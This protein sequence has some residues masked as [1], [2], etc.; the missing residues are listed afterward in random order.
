MHY[1]LN[2]TMPG[3][4]RSLQERSGNAVSD[5]LTAVQALRNTAFMAGIYEEEELVAFGR[6]VGDEARFWLVCDV[7]V[8]R[9]LEGQ[10]Y[11]VLLLKELE[12]YIRTVVPRGGQVFAFVDRPYDELCRKFGFRY[13]DEDYQRAMVRRR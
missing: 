7:M 1:Q 12:D 9:K 8:D 11:E 6:I 10:G 3:E 5:E 4:Y 2:R 13:L